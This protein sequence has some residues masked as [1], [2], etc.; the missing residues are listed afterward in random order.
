[1][2]LAAHASVFTLR[3]KSVYV[4]LL[5]AIKQIPLYAK[6]LKELYTN[7]KKVTASGS[8]PTF[9][10]KACPRLS[11]AEGALSSLNVLSVAISSISELESLDEVSSSTVS[12]KR[13]MEVEA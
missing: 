13:S 7:K 10:S 11:L 12:S 4:P 9:V 6:F 2:D 8:V 5:D 3:M 1:M